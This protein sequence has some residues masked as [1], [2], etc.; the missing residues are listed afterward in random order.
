MAVFSWSPKSD[1]ECRQE[2]DNSNGCFHDKMF[3]VK[4]FPFFFWGGGSIPSFS[5]EGFSRQSLNVRPHSKKQRPVLG[6]HRSESRWRDSH[7]VP[8]SF[9]GPMINHDI[10]GSGN[11]HRS[12]L[13]GTSPASISTTL[14]IPHI[15]DL[16]CCTTWEVEVDLETIWQ[17]AAL[18]SKKRTLRDVQRDVPEPTWNLNV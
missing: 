15:P 2:S 9:L 8:I 12:F 10:H 4:W 5:S 17:N 18:S 13:G 1:A 14:R 3:L 16:N 6:I 7:K 11:R